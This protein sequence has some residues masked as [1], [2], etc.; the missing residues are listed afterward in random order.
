LIKLLIEIEKKK[1]VAT[2]IIGKR[3]IVSKRV[4][5][6]ASQMRSRNRTLTAVHDAILEDL[7]YPAVITG[8]R[9]RYTGTKNP[10]FKITINEEAQKFIEPRVSM[11]R[12]I[13]RRLTNRNVE[14]TF[15][16]FVNYVPHPV[17]KD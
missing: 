12:H 6:H 17:K 9:V 10:T 3:N 8:K 13:Y 14:I 16:S 2:F 1:G 7:V 11:I 5:A 4:K 15:K